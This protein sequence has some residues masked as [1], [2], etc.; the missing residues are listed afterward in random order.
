[1]RSILTSIR[2]TPYQ[3]LASFL[4]LFFTLFLSLF[5]FTIISFFYGILPYVESKV[6]VIAYFDNKASEKDILKVKD[7]IK[8]SG[9]ALSIKYISKQ[10]A[11][12]I[13]KQ[14][15]KN[16]PLLIEMV[17]ADILPASLEIYANRPS[18]LPEIADYLK[19]QP[20]VQDVLFEKSLLDKLLTITDTVR[21]I[22]LFV[23]GL[24]IIISFLVLM[25]MTAFKIALKKDEIELLRLLGASTWYV[26]KP[27]LMEG[28]VFGVTSAVSAFTTFYLIYLYASSF[29]TAYFKGLPQLS[30]LGLSSASLYVWPPSLGF[31]LLSFIITVF[32]GVIIALLGNYL[33]TSKYIK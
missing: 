24:F 1:M 19:K 21:K 20:G 5:L 6:Q 26:R 25:T 8:S 11:F 13:Y 27:F 23:F 29:L 14:F 3:S 33:A 28:V 17:S 18:E 9:K 32:F 22:A 31:I 7:S 2:R 10:D 15:N 16:D 30:F 4:I 12:K